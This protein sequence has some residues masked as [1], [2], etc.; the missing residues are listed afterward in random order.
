[1]C[2][3]L[4]GHYRPRSADGCVNR[5]N[6][7]PKTRPYNGYMSHSRLAQR[8]L[9]G[10][11]GCAGVRSR[12]AYC[13][14]CSQH[15]CSSIHTHTY[16][17]AHTTGIIVLP[18]NSMTDVDDIEKGEGECSLRMLSACMDTL[19]AVLCVV[20]NSPK[21]RSNGDWSERAISSE[22]GNEKL[23]VFLFHWMWKELGLGR[24]A[25]RL[26]DSGHYY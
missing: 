13:T 25:V 26:T 11:S 24:A 17:Y 5:K 1:M 4:F 2:L 20:W 21:T 7:H 12:A 8:P 22:G 19:P 6:Q 9:W 15:G 16:A 10:F 18:L 23:G 3:F 14:Q